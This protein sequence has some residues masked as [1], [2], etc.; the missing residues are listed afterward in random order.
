MLR[1]ME[2]VEREQAER[3]RRQEEQRVGPTGTVELRWNKS[4]ME[5]SEPGSGGQR[6]ER[7]AYQ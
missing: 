5:F 1:E 2:E 4:L 3:R 7:M 6:Q